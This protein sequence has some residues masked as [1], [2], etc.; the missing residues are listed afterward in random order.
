MAEFMLKLWFSINLSVTDAWR[1]LHFK[2]VAAHPFFER[3]SIMKIFNL[4]LAVLFVLFA[5]VQ[6]N[7]P[8]PLHW[9]ALYLF[10][11]G[12]CGFAAFGRYNKYVLWAGIVVCLVWLAFTTHDFVEWIRAGSPSIVSEMKANEPH[13]ELTREF[14]GVGIC[15]VVLV[16]QAMRFRKKI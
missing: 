6:Y 11:A 14:L 10:V 15:L 1:H 8:D 9:A 7:D 12:V 16:W 5:A 2:S 3:Y 13:I 4:V